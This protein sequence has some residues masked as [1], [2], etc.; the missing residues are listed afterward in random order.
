MFVTVVF[1]L[2]CEDD[3]ENFR[4]PKPRISFDGGGNATVARNETV[5]V[6]ISLIAEGGIA[7]ITAD[8]TSLPFTVDMNDQ[9]MVTATY[10]FTA[11]VDEPVGE[12]NVAFVVTDQSNQS[13]ETSL[14]L[15]VV[16]LV[17]E[18]SENITDD[19]TLDPDNLYTITD[20]IRIK[21]GATMTIPA[22]T[23]IRAR[24][25]NKDPDD[26][27]E[28]VAAINVEETATLVINGT[29][30]NPVVFT[31]DSDNPEPG[32]WAGIEIKGGS[33]HVFNYVRIEYAGT[34]E[35]EPSESKPSLFFD[36][37]VINSTV[38]YVQIHSPKG[39]GIRLDGGTVNLK[40][41]VV[42]NAQASALRFDDDGG[43]GYVGN[44]QFIVVNNPEGNHG[45]REIQ[46]RDD[47]SVIL[48]N[49]TGI[50]P[51]AAFED[52]DEAGSLGSLDFAR[53]RDSSGPVRIHNSLIGEYP[54]D[55]I[56][57]ERFIDGEDLVTH[58][59]IFRIGGSGD[60]GIIPDG[61]SEGTT[62]LRANFVEFAGPQYN[63]MIDAE[64]TLVE[65]IK[66]GE[67]IPDVTISS[68][69]DPTAL[70]AFFEA[71]SF[72]GAIGDTDW[73]SGWTLNTDGSP[74]N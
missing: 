29:A 74:R 27:Y 71:G 34:E 13:I 46:T 62:A 51:G 20:S 33:G 10:S 4:P 73:T 57:G 60:D 22:G 72:I 23:V 25:F 66:V 14:V 50:G 44:A 70:G 1:V 64:N 41:I 61:Q 5:E 58:T 26:N 48:S 9:S 24:V 17:V 21:D 19:I 39:T 67:Y 16:G 65:G 54:D 42:N 37:G 55:G 11:A 30:D 69:F 18:F 59:Y 32:M 28:K 53:I 68:T 8:G 6:G 12:R 35:T 3:D 47:A 56:R 52:P 38:E 40:Y 7:S 63:N 45:D 15:S 36:D 49:V 31:P 43:E 2:S